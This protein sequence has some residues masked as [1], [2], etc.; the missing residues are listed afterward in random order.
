MADKLFFKAPLKTDVDENKFYIING[1]DIPKSKTVFF[2][3]DDGDDIFCLVTND[4]DFVSSAYNTDEFLATGSPL[5]LAVRHALKFKDTKLKE[6]K[7]LIGA[8]WPGVEGNV[9][10]NVHDWEAAGKPEPVKFGPFRKILGV[11][12]D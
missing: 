12:Y 3:E 6:L 4:K 11:D 2:A 1:T 5:D 10:G 8:R 9:F 7:Y